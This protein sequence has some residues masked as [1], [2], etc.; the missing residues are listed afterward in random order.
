MSIAQ[1]QR[2]SVFFSG[3]FMIDHEQLMM[4]MMMMTMMMTMTMTMMMMMIFATPAKDGIKPYV[5]HPRMVGVWH[6]VYHIIYYRFFAACYASVD[7]SPT[8]VAAEWQQFL[9]IRR[10]VSL[11]VIEA[12]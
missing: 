5:Y 10:S 6:W 2:Y 9:D 1:W 8:V 12:V 7:F 11:R 3:D 4:M